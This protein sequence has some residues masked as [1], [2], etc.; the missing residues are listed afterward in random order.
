MRGDQKPRAVLKG[1]GLKCALY[2]YVREA[3]VVRIAV[4][5]VSG[6]GLPLLCSRRLAI[7]ATC[8]KAPM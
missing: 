6:I 8:N 2:L 5:R 1:R 7:E 3:S 4:R